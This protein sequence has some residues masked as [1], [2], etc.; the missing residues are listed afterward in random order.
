MKRPALIIIITAVALLTLSAAYIFSGTLSP[1]DIQSTDKEQSS[2]LGGIQEYAPEDIAVFEKYSAYIKEYSAKPL[3]DIIIASAKFFLE[4]PYVAATLEK[5][6]EQLV[7]NLRELDCVTF[8]EN[9]YALSY[10]AH[11]GEPTFEK[12]C[13][14]LK[15]IRYRN[16]E[17]GDYTD[18]LHYT[19]DW[20]FENQ[21][22]GLVVL[23]S[24][25]SQQSPTAF[26]LNIMSSNP[27]VYKQLKGN[28][29]LIDKIIAI[30]KEASGREF[31]Y[32]P[33][34]KIESA[35]NHFKNG[36]MVALV[37]SNKGIDISHV[38]LIYFDSDRL[39][40]IHASSREKK[41]VIEK[42]SLQD[43]CIPTKSNMGIIVAR[44]QST[45][46]N[47]RPEQE[48][49]STRSDSEYRSSI[50]KQDRLQKPNAL[51]YT[52]PYLSS[53]QPWR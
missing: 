17:A 44:P 7:V 31:L 24:G 29:L 2:S 52:T 40:F 43:Y 37:T 32:F 53:L 10:T 28:Q 51:P 50:C 47:S 15:N 16:G 41:V 27:E 38:G 39:T 19:S 49:N 1:E 8:V 45:G 35:R 21:R 36:D 22:K 18:R 4:T 46:E 42:L 12:Y 48:G 20:L 6:P 3:E 34:N 30:E 5:E 26:T 9:V 33:K 13:G 11:N 23:L 25:K 14:N